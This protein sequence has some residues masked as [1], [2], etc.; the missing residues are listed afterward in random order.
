[1]KGFVV[2][3]ALALYPIAECFVLLSFCPLSRVS[4]FMNNSLI[5]RI[6]SIRSDWTFPY[7]L[8]ASARLT[9]LEHE[10]ENLASTKQAGSGYGTGFAKKRKVVEERMLVKLARKQP[11]D[12]PLYDRQ[13]DDDYYDDP[14]YTKNEHDP[15]SEHVDDQPEVASKQAHDEHDM[16]DAHDEEAMDLDSDLHAIGLGDVPFRW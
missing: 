14:K 13:L 16:N 9:V 10:N 1:V 15:D 5:M 6:I 11:D 4:L 12:Q 7:V 2:A 3:H 8:A